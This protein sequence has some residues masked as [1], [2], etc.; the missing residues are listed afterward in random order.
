M[1]VSP[2]MVDVRRKILVVDD[3]VDILE[4]IEL[5]LQPSGYE[6]LLASR[7]DRAMQL[8]DRHRVD[9]V[10]C[11]IRMPGMNGMTIIERLRERAPELPIII[12]T[13]FAAPDTLEQCAKVGVV[14]VLR[15]PFVFQDLSN[16]VK[17][18]LERTRARR[19]VQ[20]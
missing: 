10:I 7:G 13:G 17:S 1:W 11:D 18:A 4:M 15:K 14:E 5:G 16:A 20:P 19:V 8:F 12:V 9:L 2:A 3:E 6:L